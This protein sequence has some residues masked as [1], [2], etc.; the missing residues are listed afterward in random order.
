MATPAA[1]RFIK[2]VE[3]LPN[4]CWL[5][6]GARTGKSWNGGRLRYGN[7][8]NGTKVVSAHRWSREHFV[9]SIPEGLDAGH[10]CTTELCVHPL[11]VR[12]MTHAEN[13]SASVPGKQL[14]GRQRCKRG[15][16]LSGENLLVSGGA[17]YCRECRKIREQRFGL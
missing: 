6:N 2:K 14:G 15:H 11:H 16:E 5:W 8:W 13:M 7:F 3:F 1:V 9:G 10:L 4:G 12:P 17:R